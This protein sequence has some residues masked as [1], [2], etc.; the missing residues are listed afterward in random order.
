MPFV[1]VF[2]S[3]EI[4]RLSEEVEALRVALKDA[5][6][7]QFNLQNYEV[8]I[9]ELTEKCHV[10]EMEREEYRE[11]VEKLNIICEKLYEELEIM[12]ARFADIDPTIKEK[13][14]LERERSRQLEEEL[15]KWRV[16]YS[17]LEASKNR[18]MEDMR[19]MLESQRKSMVDR[20]IRELT[21]RSESERK[22]L[23]KEIRKLREG[24]EEKDANVQRVE[25]LLAKARVQIQELQRYEDLVMDYENKFAMISQETV[26]LNDL[27][28]HKHEEIEKLAS[29]EAGLKRRIS[30]LEQKL[31]EAM[32]GGE[33]ARQLEGEVREWRAKYARA[34]DQNREYKGELDKIPEFQMVIHQISG[35]SEKLRDAV[36]QKIGEIDE[37]KSRCHRVEEQFRQSRAEEEKKIPLLQAKIEQLGSE[38]ARLNEALKS[39]AVEIENWKSKF[40]EAEKRANRLDGLEQDKRKLEEKLDANVRELTR[41]EGRSRQLEMELG[42][43]G[44]LEKELQRERSHRQDSG[45]EIERL[46]GAVQQASLKAEEFRKRCENLE[47]ELQSFTQVQEEVRVYRQKEAGFT[48]ELD[49]INGIIT[50]KVREIQALKETFARYESRMSQYQGFEKKLM[51]SVAQTQKLIHDLDESRKEAGFLQDRLVSTESDI[52]KLKNEVVVINQEKDQSVRLLNTKAQELEQSRMEFERV[53]G[54]LNVLRQKEAKYREL[55]VRHKLFRNSSGRWSRSWASR[56]GGWR[57]SS[58]GTRRSRGSWRTAAGSSPRSSARA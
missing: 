37:W 48:R 31:R 47:R 24:L 41:V 7:Q 28:R 30:E 26:R 36:R 42:K 51:E 34:E 1:V 39:R 45:R 38:H 27:L 22:G 6:R 44:D 56:A 8:Q 52:R 58:R 29:S 2:Q 14:R 21:L 15:E 53:Q 19:L 18:E 3:I 23:E 10:Y 9:R 35:E 17:A 11:E 40:G 57:P 43:L 13:F 33:R 49:R 20:E 32:E 12:K 5:E 55:E 54:Q 50:E 25:G 16:R 46:N 4:E